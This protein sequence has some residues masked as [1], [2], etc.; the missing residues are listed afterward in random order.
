MDESNCSGPTRATLFGA[1]AHHTQS[2]TQNFQIPFKGIKLLLDYC[3]AS[4]NVV[5]MGPLNNLSRIID[6][7]CKTGIS[8]DLAEPSSS[9]S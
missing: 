3:G 2:T 7:S 9:R 1:T 5:S 6:Q 8:A 4:V